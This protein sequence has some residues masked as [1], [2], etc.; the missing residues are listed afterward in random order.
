MLNTLKIDIYLKCKRN[1]QMDIDPTVIPC[2]RPKLQFYQ[3]ETWQKR[4]EGTA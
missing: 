4:N 3:I 1:F 2:E